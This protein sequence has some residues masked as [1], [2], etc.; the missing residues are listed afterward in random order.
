MIRKT[1]GISA[2]LLLKALISSLMLFSLICWASC[3]HFFLLSL[4]LSLALSPFLSLSSQKARPCWHSIRRDGQSWPYLYFMSF[5]SKRRHVA[6]QRNSAASCLCFGLKMS[7]SS[8]RC[9]HKYIST[10]S[11]VQDLCAPCQFDLWQ[12]YIWF[13]L[14]YLSM[15][16]WNP[17][18][19][20]YF[21]LLQYPVGPKE[22]SKI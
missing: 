8:L 3:S 19:V 14:Y 18:T 7:Q 17:R 11:F 22:P 15:L 20:L 1:D 9:R 10:K 6:L 12:N 2:I 16:A 21:V 5:W 4:S 13:Y